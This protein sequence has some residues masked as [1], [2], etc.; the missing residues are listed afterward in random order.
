MPSVEK[1]FETSYM[2]ML[3]LKGENGSQLYGYFVYQTSSM[4]RKPSISHPHL[5]FLK[6]RMIYGYI[7]YDY[8]FNPY[9]L[10]M[11]L[12]PLMQ[13]LIMSPRKL[14]ACHTL[15]PPYLLPPLNVAKTQNRVQTA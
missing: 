4:V 9:I 13:A 2:N 1:A 10:K 11:Q 14:P 6:Y 8:I 7:L 15:P 12:Q 3:S 5:S